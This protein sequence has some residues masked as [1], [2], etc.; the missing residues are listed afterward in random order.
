MR[1]SIGRGEKMP[2]KD[3]TLNYAAYINGQR[4]EKSI[5]PVELTPKI[6]M[7]PIGDLHSV[8]HWRCGRCRCAVVVYKDDPK[9]DD[10]PWC[11][12]GIEWEDGLLSG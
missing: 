3:T 8:P 6:M 4:Y 12:C 2:P 9:P 10:C 7:K 5:E 1:I 11:G